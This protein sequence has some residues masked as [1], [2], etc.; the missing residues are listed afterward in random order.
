MKE[1]PPRPKPKT[2]NIGFPRSRGEV[3]FENALYMAWGLFVLGMFAYAILRA[4]GVIPS[5]SVPETMP[6]EECVEWLKPAVR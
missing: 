1:V 2:T 6:S 4:E 3:I 5:R